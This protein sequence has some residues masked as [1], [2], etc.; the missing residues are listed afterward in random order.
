MSNC[1][2][3]S[4]ANRNPK[5]WFHNQTNLRKNLG[6]PTQSCLEPK[7]ATEVSLFTRLCWCCCNLSTKHQNCKKM[8]SFLISFWWQPGESL[9][10][11]GPRSGWW[12]SWIWREWMWEHLSWRYDISK[13]ECP[14]RDSASTKKQTFCQKNNCDISLHF[15]TFHPHMLSL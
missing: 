8:T 13:E 14:Q 15:N 12:L 1:R 9:P 3:A 5:L 10:R 6:G 2:S 11:S 7:D 4:L